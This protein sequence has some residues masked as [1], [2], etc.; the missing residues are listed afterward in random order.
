MSMHIPAWTLSDQVHLCVHVINVF[1]RAVQ[2]LSPVYCMK[3]TY[4]G[5][6]TSSLSVLK[7]QQLGKLQI[8]FC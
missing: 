5:L 3:M 4:K 2:T 7:Q 6:H 1:V 8:I